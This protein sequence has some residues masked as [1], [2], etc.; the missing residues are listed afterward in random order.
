M[1]S[2]LL[3]V[4]TPH[5][6]ITRPSTVVPENQN[7]LNGYP[8]LAFKKF[9]DLTG[10]TIVQQTNLKG[11]PCSEAELQKITNLLYQGVVF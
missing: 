6:I 1:H 5:L 7:T 2:G 3:G 4:L 11:I 9:S 10:F 8:C